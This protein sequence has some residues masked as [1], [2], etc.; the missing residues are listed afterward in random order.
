MNEKCLRCGAKL[1]ESSPEI[2]GVKDLLKINFCPKCEHFESY[3]ALIPLIVFKGKALGGI[4]LGTGQFRAR[5]ESPKEDFL[6]EGAE[7]TVKTFPIDQIPTPRISIP[8][9]PELKQGDKVIVAGFMQGEWTEIS[10]PVISVILKNL[11]NG[12]TSIFVDEQIK[13]KKGIRGSFNIRNPIFIMAEKR[14]EKIMGT[15]KEPSL[16]DK[17]PYCSNCGVEL[18]PN[19]RFCHKCG[20]SVK[21]DGPSR[22]HSYLAS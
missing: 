21:V 2:W 22:A 10:E 6:R 5:I 16:L 20:K 19:A 3:I 8:I 4:E 12:I 1:K 7:I 11:T 18:K 13:L 14:I 9:Y 17:M 15:W